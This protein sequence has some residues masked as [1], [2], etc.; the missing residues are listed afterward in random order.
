MLPWET[1]R[2][3]NARL[4]PVALSMLN[5]V[6]IAIN[7][8]LK[9]RNCRKIMSISLAAVTLFHEAYVPDSMSHDPASSVFLSFSLLFS[10]LE[11]FLV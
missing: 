7:K 8:G 2:R 4:L 3:L 5:R 10:F 1:S 9:E 6:I 11:S